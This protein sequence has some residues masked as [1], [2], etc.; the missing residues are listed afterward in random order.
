MAE[1]SSSIERSESGQPI[2]RY[3][4]PKHDFEPA[5]GQ[6]ATIEGVE[7]HIRQHIGEPS[8]VWHEFVSSLVHIDVHVVKPTPE[9]NYITLVTTGM[10]DKAMKTPKN[11]VGFEYA[12]L[13]MTLPPDYP[14][15]TEGT[16]GPPVDSAKKNVVKT[17]FGGKKTTTDQPDPE[18]YWPI[19]MIKYLA[20]F[21]HEYDAWLWE[22]HTIPNGDP[23]A[24]VTKGTL[25]CGVLLSPPFQFADEI[26]PLVIENRN[27]YFWNVMPLYAEEMTFKLKYGVDALYDRFSEHRISPILSIHRR[28][29]CV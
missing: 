6:S 10:S 5:V 7:E 28:N 9:R 3:G 2:Y 1:D 19:R 14:L 4:Q 17:L 16:V 11:A 27:I 13:V 22:G 26:N 21:P 23:P 25:L 8:L 15:P 12:E 20:R 18:W 24:P 29:V